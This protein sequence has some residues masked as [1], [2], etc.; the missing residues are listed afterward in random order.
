ML[1][2][3]PILGTTV[4]GIGHKARHGKDSIAEHLAKNY[5]AMRFS[6]SDAL[7][8]VARV[9]FG[10]REKDAPLLQVL[11]T[12]VFRRRDED[13][14]VRTL[15]H[16]MKDKRPA[17]AVISDVRFPNEADMVHDLGGT[18]IKV[19]RFNEDGSPFV[20]PDR[21][22]DHPSE[23]GL[24]NYTAWDFSLRSEANALPSTLASV[25][26]IAQWIIQGQLK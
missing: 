20:A 22:A 19:S 4:I 13:V 25:D 14:W 3:E 10:M 24:D 6:F 9:V 23:T 5:G 18:L 2:W 12:D 8:D 7:Y 21:P 15:Y 17:L 1:K 26:W 16:K 11:G